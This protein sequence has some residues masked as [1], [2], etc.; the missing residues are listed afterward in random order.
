ML[1]QADSEGNRVN[2]DRRLRDNQALINKSG[3]PVLTDKKQ[4]S[5]T[6]KKRPIG[7]GLSHLEAQFF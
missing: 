4:D 3:T 2:R 5:G 6:L 1:Y 7:G